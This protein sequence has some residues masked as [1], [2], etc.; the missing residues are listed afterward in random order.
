MSK[1]IIICDGGSLG[2]HV[3]KEGAKAYGSFIILPDIR[4]ERFMME[5]GVG[6]NNDAE[7]LI[8]ISALKYLYA[9]LTAD[10][11]K[12]FPIET[13]VVIQTDSQ[14]VIGQMSKGWKIKAPNILTHVVHLQEAMSHF[15]SVSFEHIAGL[16]MKKILGH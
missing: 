3:G 2:N 8:A 11:S 10:P 6:S 7:Y 14:L 13:D 15:K 9:R 5:F 1:Y 12:S 16:V 4:T